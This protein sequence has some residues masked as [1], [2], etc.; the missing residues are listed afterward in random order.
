M[1]EELPKP[2]ALYLYLMSKADEEGRRIMRNWLINY[3][4]G[5][6]KCGDCPWWGRSGCEAPYHV[7]KRCPKAQDP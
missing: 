6:L 2:L 3:L 1:S 7:W 5:M 4:R